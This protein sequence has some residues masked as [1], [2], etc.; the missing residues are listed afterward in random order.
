MADS[1]GPS[2]VESKIRNRNSW[3]RVFVIVALVGLLGWKFADT[4]VRLD[5]TRF[6]FSDLLALVLALFAMGLS[7]AFYLK[8]TDTTNTF[9]D[10]TYR[11][12][13]DVSE[14]LGRI[15]AGFGERLRHLDE[16]YSGLIE[17]VSTLPRI[18]PQ[19][20]KNEIQDE[21]AKLKAALAERDKLVQRFAEKAKVQEH[22]KEEF[23][24]EISTR[25]GTIANLMSELEFLR[26]RLGRAESVRDAS[27][28]HRVRASEAQERTALYASHQVLD[29]LGRDAVAAGDESVVRRRFRHLRDELSPGFLGDLR[30]LDFIDGDADLTPRGLQWLQS[31]ATGR[32]DD[33]SVRRGPRT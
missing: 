4:P 1:Y 13:R 11:F 30:E 6:D 19:E 14:I 17:K 9:Y 12:T 8:A 10:N 20:V 29:M 7:I 5:L 2:D 26:H 32:P 23:V 16:G 15:E 22:E 21:Q 18:Q 3:L 31:I 33:A 25:D 28:G 27:I 24:K